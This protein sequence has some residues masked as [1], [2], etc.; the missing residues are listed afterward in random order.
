MKLLTERTESILSKATLPAGST[1]FNVPDSHSCMDTEQL[2]VLSD[3][4][5]IFGTTSADST[6]KVTID[7]KGERHIYEPSVMAK[8]GKVVIEWGGKTY[9][10]PEGIAFSSGRCLATFEVDETEY[11]L[12]VRVLPIKKEDAK[13]KLQ[14]AWATCAP[15]DKSDFLGKQ[16]SKGTIADILAQAYPT[17]YKLGE[18]IGEHKVYSYYMGSF[19][20][21]VL[22][23]EDGRHVRANTSLQNKLA[24]YEE[25]V[26][27]V[28]ESAPAMLTVEKST[29]KTSTGFAIYPTTLVSYRNIDLPV[30][31]FGLVIN[32]GVGVEDADSSYSEEL[33]TIAF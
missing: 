24:S 9:P 8:D 5:S 19:D 18:V 2:L 4:K 20:K 12:K 17:I 6:F 11:A 22:V 23:L 15:N 29:S 13:T 7:K 16:W 21:Y 30:F 28:S 25:M 33:D 26:I 31:D 14:T 32:A 10:L 27:E 3:F 1:S